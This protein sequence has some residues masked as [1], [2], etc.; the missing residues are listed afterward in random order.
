MNSINFKPSTSRLHHTVENLTQTPRTCWDFDGQNEIIEDLYQ[1]LEGFG[2]SEIEV[3]PFH[4]HL[5]QYQNL[6]VRINPTDQKRLV[7]GAHY[8]A[9]EGTSGADD[10]A[11]AVAGLLETARLLQPYSDQLTNLEFVF[12]SCEEPPFFGTPE[13]GSYVHAQS[14]KQQQIEAEAII[15]EMIGYFSEQPGSQNYPIPGMD[16]LFP[17]VGNFIALVS[18]R[19]SKGLLKEAKKSFATAQLEIG[20]ESLADPFNIP[21]LG[22]SDHRNYWQFGFPA[23]MVTDTAFMRNP[24]YHQPSDTIET[25]DFNK[26]A[27]VVKGICQS[28]LDRSGADQ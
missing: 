13:M 3:Q 8:D 27:E 23:L 15:L 5:G 7:V 12:Y 24:H 22:F 19:A 1:Q 11:S 20:V 4:N 28:V 2:Y 21:E 14:L 17:S 18:N 10:N 26:M 25:L 16:L 9:V 6:I